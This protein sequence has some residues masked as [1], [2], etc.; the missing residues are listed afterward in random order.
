MSRR[1]WLTSALLSLLTLATLSP[2]SPAAGGKMLAGQVLVASEDIGDPR[3]DHTVIYIVKHERTGALG[4]IVNRPRQ[5]VPLGPLLR[6]LGFDDT[7][8]TG[9]LRLHYGGPVEPG[10]AFLLHT[11]EYKT[12]GTE[13]VS[14]EAS[15]T[16]L[17]GRPTVLS[18]IGHGGGPRR[19]LFVFG[20]A[21]WGPGQLEAEIDNGAWITVQADEALLFD[22]D[23][24][25]K[26]DRAMARRRIT[27]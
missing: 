15:V 20:Y 11:A 6:R 23:Y 9:S 19:Y 22:T 14:P 26:W 27:L 10:S 7:G 25:S 17:S 4:L 5:E 8:V 21:G 2:A 12:Q 13:P 16:P 24:A 1:P 3:F 18:E